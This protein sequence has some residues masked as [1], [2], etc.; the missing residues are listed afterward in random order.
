MLFLIYSIYITSLAFIRKNIIL[1]IPFVLNELF[2]LIVSDF[3]GTIF[4]VVFWLASTLLIPCLIDVYVVLYVFKSENI[5]DTSVQI[6]SLVKKYYR[7]FVLLYFLGYILAYIVVF[8]SLLLYSSIA[9]EV[10]S[11]P[12]L[13]VIYSF[14]T[15]FGFLLFVVTGLGLRILIYKN[16]R[17]MAAF[18][19]S[20]VEVQKNLYFYFFI[21]LLGAILT[22]FPSFISFF[23]FSF[24]HFLPIAEFQS[25]ISND[26]IRIT[27]ISFSSVWFSVALTYAFLERNKKTRYVP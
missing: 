7:R 16:I 8:P 11:A 19:E 14:S 21:F 25:Y 17:T 10:N 26:F 22:M 4:G 18:R 2:K 20:F 27:L 9:K 6:A 3:K 5:I 24:I 23:S 1:V 13:V 12:N 15:V